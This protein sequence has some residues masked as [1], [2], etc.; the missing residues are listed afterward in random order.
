MQSNVAW[1]DAK[2]VAVVVSVLLET[3]AEGKSPTY[4]P[5]TT[6]LKPGTADLPG[7]EWSQYGAEEGVWRIL[8]ILERTGVPAT[9]FANALSAERYPDLVRAIVGCGHE[10]HAHGYAQ[11]QYLLEMSDE[12]QR[13][14]IRAC[15]DILERH[16]GRRPDGWVTPVYGSNAIT[17]ELLVREGVKWHADALNTSLPRIRHT[18]AGS[19]VALPWSDFVDNRVLRSNPHDYYDAYVETFEY[20]RSQET[21]GLINI[22]IHGHFGGRP[23]MSA[24]FS[25]LLVHLAQQPDVWF[26]RHSALAAWFAALGVE[27]IPASRLLRG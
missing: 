1:P 17:H 5:R 9:V 8:G 2:R 15:L 19:I 12:E 3:W 26:V 23:L 4:F 16:A 20:L 10:V 13:K 11:N 27:K 25:K 24:M 21:L 7:R 14:T 22:A 6:P 18:P